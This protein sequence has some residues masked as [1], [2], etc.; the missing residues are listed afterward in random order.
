MRRSERRNVH[1]RELLATARAS[2]GSKAKPS[3]ACL[4]RATS[5]AY[6]A[7]FHCLARAGADLLIGSPGANRS[8]HAWT[9]TYRALEHGHAKGQ[10]ENRSVVGKFPKA[11]ED[12]A[13]A[14]VTL[15]KKRHSADYNPD[16]RFLKS[17]VL[18]DIQ[19]A[20]DAIMAF[21]NEKISDRRAFCAWVL[22]RVPKKQ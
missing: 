5:T 14:F 15:Q 19:L 21:K 2:L 12:F 4:R 8:R 18:S 1:S 7:L 22:F 11:I 3:Q 20:E 10:C 17:S 6:Y 16:A 13:N 9:Q